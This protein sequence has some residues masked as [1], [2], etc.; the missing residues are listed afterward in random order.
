MLGGTRDTG[1]W[2]AGKGGP[3]NLWEWGWTSLGA[4]GSCSNSWEATL[5]PLPLAIRLRWRWS[6]WWRWWWWWWWSWWWYFRQTTGCSRRRA[7]QARG[8]SDTEPPVA[9]TII[10]TATIIGTIFNTI[11]K[12]I[13][14]TI[15]RTIINTRTFINT[16][17]NT[18]F[19][20]IIRTIINTIFRIISSKPPSKIL[21]ELYH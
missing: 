18:I 5:L 12:T 6:W 19:R 4:Y 7:V 1:V 21:S 8:W 17:T 11:I 13:I 14:G 3:G 15:I 2:G 9:Q 16:I 10:N 20:T